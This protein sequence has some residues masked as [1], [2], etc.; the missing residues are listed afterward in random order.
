MGSIASFRAVCSLLFVAALLT[1]LALAFFV[2]VYVVMTIC[3]ACVT[4]TDEA[5]VMVLVS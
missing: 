3:A 4:I 1:P 5:N 2:D